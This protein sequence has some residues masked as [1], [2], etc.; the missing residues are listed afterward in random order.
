MIFSIEVR[1][2]VSVYLHPKLKTAQ[3]KSHEYTKIVFTKPTMR[4]AEIK[5]YLSQFFTSV[6]VI[7]DDE[8]EIERVAK[9]ENATSGDI[10]FIANPKYE[11]YL[12]ETNASAVILSNKIAHKQPKENQS[13]IVMEDAYTGF[14]FVLEKLMPKREGLERGIH[15]TAVVQS[16]I[17]ESASISANVFIGKNC[18][19]GERVQIYPNVVILDECEIGSDSIIYPNVTLYSGTKIGNRVIIHS[20]SVIGADGFGFAP[21]K[22]GS[23]KKI[24]QIGIVVI[25]DD[26]EIG[27]NTCIDRATLG[28]TRIGQG[29]KLDNLIQIAHNVVIGKHTVIASQTGVSGS[30]KIGE[31][32]MIAGQV[33]FVGHIEIGN[34]I[35]VGAQSGV[36]K[37]FLKEGEFIRGYPARPLREQLRQEAYQAKLKDL[38]EQ[39]KQLEKAL[40]ELKRGSEPTV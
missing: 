17:P 20:G 28:E 40:S 10:A 29:V 7:G 22:D 35:T 32:C 26:V 4:V 8:I 13:F 14:V 21:Q 39:V 18:T 36:A 27:A 1:A 2:D 5:S 25:E 12:A 19:I 3:K 9:I 33:G 23:Y 24:P 30:T 6:E 11:K 16:P 31:Q 34:K 15:S 38:F 37:S